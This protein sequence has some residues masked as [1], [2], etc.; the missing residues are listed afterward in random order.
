MAAQLRDIHAELDDGETRRAYLCARSMWVTPPVTERQGHAAAREECERQAHLVR[1]PRPP[2]SAPAH[3]SSRPPCVC[4][5]GD[6]Q[7]AL[8]QMTRLTQYQ[9]ATATAAPAAGP[10]AREQ[11]ATVNVSALQS[12]HH[13]GMQR[14]HEMV[15]Q[16]AME[17]VR[18]REALS[19][20]Q[21]DKQ[22]AEVQ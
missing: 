3:C 10:A 17:I 1:V 4:Q 18:L 13:E 11:P 12:E 14:L 15:D 19:T 20:A 2:R 9:A 6:L 8:Q 21:A 22:R 5:I 7:E 16:S